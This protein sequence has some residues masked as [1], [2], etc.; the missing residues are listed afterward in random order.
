MAERYYGQAI[1]FLPEYGMPHNQLGTLAGTKNYGLDAAYSYLRC[2]LSPHPFEGARANLT[3]LLERNHRRHM[4]IL[5]RQLKN[6]RHE[7]RGVSRF[8]RVRRLKRCL[9]GFLDLMAVFIENKQR[10]GAQKIQQICHEEL[11]EMNS[12]LY[13]RPDSGRDSRDDWTELDCFSSAWELLFIEENRPAFLDSGLLFKL[14]LIA[15]MVTHK[16]QVPCG[17]LLVFMYYPL[18]VLQN[19]YDATTITF[20]IF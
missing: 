3:K 5:R 16:L 13:F 18:F 10:L 19:V 20:V 17:H 11:A 6:R 1:Q 4:D 7:S 12:C 2:L 8:A 15:I 9:I 14:A